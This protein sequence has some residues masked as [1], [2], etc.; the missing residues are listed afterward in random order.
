LAGGIAH[1]FNNMLSVILGYAQIGLERLTPQDPFY[2]E[3]LQIEKAGQRSAELTGQ[4]LA[5]SRKQV[6][7]PVVINLNEVIAEQH[8]MLA[9]LIG[10]DISI[11]FK[12][13]DG[14]WN[15]RIDPSQVDQI[16]T[17]LAV[18]ARDAIGGVGTV[19]I[20]TANSTLDESTGT[21]IL[22]PPGDY[23]ML[24]FSDTG[25]GMDKETLERIF[26]P[27]F[28]TKGEGKGTGLGLS[29]LYGIV[30]QNEGMI[31]VYSE[32]GMGT[33]FRIYF[34]RIRAEKY[35]PVEKPH[36][37]PLTGNETVL[38]VE[39]EEQIRTLARTVLEQY[40]YKVLSAA[41]PEDACLLC[42]KN[43][44]DIHLLLS[45]VVMPGM[46][47]KELRARIEAIKPGIRTLFMSGYTSDVIA[48]RGVI[49]L[50]IDF[51]AKPFTL[52]SLAG[53]VRAVLDA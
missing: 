49:D 17:N 18:N 13:A 25:V 7:A 3:L 53:K 10:E 51:I 36:E 33:T 21:S 34:P 44:G 16:L 37:T 9:R 4:L 30:R 35:E 20:A 50:G 26:E 14:L 28:T 12:P 47:G 52:T 43:A 5:F 41:T 48:H 8:K 1:D 23:M 24:T 42:E 11:A 22:L 29:T 38:I 27:F 40:G 15:I 39:D 6:T 45:D 31:H 46:N 19:T 32:P 2:K